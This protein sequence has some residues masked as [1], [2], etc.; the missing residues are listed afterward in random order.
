MG[1][2]MIFQGFQPSD[3]QIED[4]EQG[5]PINDAEH[6]RD[7]E[8]QRQ[9]HLQQQQQDAV[10]RTLRYCTQ[11]GSDEEHSGEEKEEEHDEE[12]KEENYDEQKLS[13]HTQEQS[14]TSDGADSLSSTDAN[15][16]KTD[17]AEVPQEGSD[18]PDHPQDSAAAD[19]APTVNEPNSAAEDPMEEEVDT[20]RMSDY[21]IYNLMASHILFPMPNN[22]TYQPIYQ[23]LQEYIPDMEQRERALQ[24]L[25]EIAIVM[26]SEAGDLQSN[27]QSTDAHDIFTPYQ[28]ANQQLM[29]TM[30]SY[31]EESR[32]HICPF[33]G[34]GGDGDGDDNGDGGWHWD[35]EDE[36]SEDEAD[37]DPNFKANH[38]KSLAEQKE[39]R[40]LRQ[41]HYKTWRCYTI[42]LEFFISFLT[43]QR[44]KLRETH[45]NL[46]NECR[47]KSQ[48]LARLRRNQ[49]PNEV[50]FQLLTPPVTHAYYSH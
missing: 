27:V 42:T 39:R 9:Q 32:K 18:H 45:L 12:I 4:L 47:T 44:S 2:E 36:D 10:T 37:S 23:A 1:F 46:R 3:E 5:N 40:L 49:Q 22:P 19:I 28:Q 11:H 38:K 6:V 24:L 20:I 33:V 13:P 30:A 16:P 7:A 41:R 8:Q 17:A 43:M 14:H 26:F 25:Q 35:S 29:Q 50:S 48:I 31:I 15:H 34:G 21:S